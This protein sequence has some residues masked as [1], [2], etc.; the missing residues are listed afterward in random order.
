MITKQQFDAWLEDPVTLEMRTY[1]VKWQQ[2]LRQQI[3]EVAENS[4]MRT[5][6]HKEILLS[7]L[8]SLRYQLNMLRDITR[9]TFEHLEN[10]HKEDLEMK[11]HES[12]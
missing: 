2:L 11:N 5:T 7:T 4:S 6:E 10:S 3:A 12:D 9:I 8:E 1:T